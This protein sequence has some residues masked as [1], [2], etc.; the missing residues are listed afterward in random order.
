MLWMEFSSM[1]SSIPHLSNVGFRNSAEG[2]GGGS[3]IEKANDI[4]HSPE[5]GGNPAPTLIPQGRRKLQVWS[6]VASNLGFPA[7]GGSVV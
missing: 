6:L 1:L 5:P 3:Y 4:L 2:G 7:I